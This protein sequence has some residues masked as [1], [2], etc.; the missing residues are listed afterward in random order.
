MLTH[1]S[2]GGAIKGG[3]RQPSAG[4]DR[5]RGGGPPLRPGYNGVSGYPPSASGKQHWP[6]H[7]KGGGV[8]G[9]SWRGKSTNKG[10]GF[11]NGSHVGG[12]GTPRKE[13]EVHFDDAPAE[14]TQYDDMAQEECPF[15]EDDAE[16]APLEDDNGEEVP[17][18]LKEAVEAS[19]KLKRVIEKE[20][21]NGARKKRKLDAGT[22][23][24]SV[25]D[26]E[27][28]KEL[29]RRY[30]LEDDVASKFVLGSLSSEALDHLLSVGWVPDGSHSSLKK[31]SAELIAD[32]ALSAKERGII[33][34]MICDAVTAFAF[35]W[36]LK[37]A[38][39]QLLRGLNHKDIRYCLREYD[40][41]R[42]MEELAEE[43]SATMPEEGRASDAAPDK[44]GI[45]TL[46][47]FVR[48]ELIDPFADALVVGDANLTFALA[49]AQHRKALGHVGRIVATTFEPIEVLR[50]RYPEIDSTVQ[51]LEDHHA[52]VWHEVDCTRIAIDA[53]F[54]GHEEAF[55]AVY[56]NYPHAGSV[57]GF[58]DAHPFVRWRHENLMHLFFR[59][60]RA[61]VKPGGQVK[62][63]SN[64]NATGVRY[65]DIISAGMVN[66]FAH[67]ETFP[68]TDWQLKGYHRSYGDKR[69]ALQR[70][71]EEAGYRSQN[72]DK[73]MVYS[74]CFA[75]TGEAVPEAP[76]RMPPSC[77]DLM[78]S[79]IVCGCGF[80]CQYSMKRCERNQH[81]FKPAGQHRQADEGRKEEVIMALYDR[82]LS[83]IK[84]VH[85]G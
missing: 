32:F 60:L 44:P 68:F 65:S 13:E 22:K 72:T 47:R 17:E 30:R 73:D 77:K 26:K 49:L 27:K 40:G 19:L 56:Y 37:E 53:R 7:G 8:N 24:V 34:N 84:G 42:S 20:T 3:Y 70:P 12:K 4:M 75:P 74:F 46:G 43:A 2:L 45:S 64:A 54:R 38:D 79:T 21:V 76:V 18:H 15:E 48:L 66:E 23:V 11:K 55:G 67:T 83:E 39:A 71:G 1:G 80:I 62:I 6:S 9:D 63:A 36:Q 82:F 59:A 14:E 25:D 57:R 50:Q 52:E 81:H 29:L 61:F 69:D 85:V 58:F 31:S 16:A 33:H 51:V 78:D 10:N 28:I 5:Y 35:R 41:S